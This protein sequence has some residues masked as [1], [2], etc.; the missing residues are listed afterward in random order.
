MNC[1]VLYGRRDKSEGCRFYLFK[2]ENNLFNSVTTFE[3]MCNHD[4]YRLI[5][6]NISGQEHLAAAC[7]HCDKIYLY[8]LATRKWS[9]AFEDDNTPYAM[10]TGAENKLY[11]HTVDNNQVIE[12]NCSKPK[13]GSPNR[14]FETNCSNMYYLPFP[15]NLLV[16]GNSLSNIVKAFSLDTNRVV[17]E[18]DQEI[19]GKR[20]AP[21]GLLY[22]APHDALLVA[23]V[24]N[25][26]VLVLNPRNGVHV[27]TRLLPQ[28][29][30]I[31]GLFFYD[32]AQKIIIHHLQ[33]G[34]QCDM[35]SCFSINI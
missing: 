2:I 22:S 8:S 14:K 7:T 32:N 33:Y 16:V 9:V 27:Q 20:P 17:W 11:L 23:D 21:S 5:P 25:S 24:T 29:G 3:G 31:Y 15:Y 6:L 30:Y 26:R 19:D 10:C 34:S 18:F 35:I 13:F 1:I 12:L 28:L 4:A